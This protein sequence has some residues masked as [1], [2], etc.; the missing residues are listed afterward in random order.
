MPTEIVLVAVKQG[1]QRLIGE[2][3]QPDHI[4]LC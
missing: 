2:V 4:L 1:L 3:I